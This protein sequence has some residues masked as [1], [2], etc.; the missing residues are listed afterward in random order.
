MKKLLIIV[1][2]TG[3]LSSGA[4]STMISE[5]D[6]ENIDRVLEFGVH[7]FLNCLDKIKEATEK[8]VRDD[9]LRTN[10]I[11]IQSHWNSFKETA[12][13]ISVEERGKGVQD[14]IV[15]V[16]RT[17]RRL[18]L[19]YKDDVKN[20]IHTLATEENAQLYQPVI[21]IFK[22]TIERAKANDMWGTLAENYF[23]EAPSIQSEPLEF[24]CYLLSTNVMET[25]VVNILKGGVELITEIKKI[26][27]DQLS[28]RIM[29]LSEDVHEKLNEI[30]EIQKEKED[31]ELILIISTIAKGAIFYWDRYLNS[32]D[33]PLLETQYEDVARLTPVNFGEARVTL[34][35]LPKMSTLGTQATTCVVR[36]LWPGGFK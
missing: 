32:T 27:F 3:L 17:L 4:E 19:Y 33:T 10:R 12:N 14:D 21:K 1:A 34:F 2:L 18:V 8:L 7:V 16:A 23:P 13:K 30:Y 22:G 15:V 26:D 28:E 11:A 36:V 35:W 6:Y 29:R 24:L 9:M 25:I 20:M 31:D 5:K